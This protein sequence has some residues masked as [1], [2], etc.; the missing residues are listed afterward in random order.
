MSDPRD[1]ILRPVVSE[2]SLALV[3]AHPDHRAYTFVVAPGSN[4][5]EIRHAVEAIFGVEVI[6]ITTLNRQGKRKRNRGRAT[7]TRRPT[8]KRAVVTLAAGQEIEL[9]SES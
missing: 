2:K 5:A 7:F 9:L 6:K 8:T 3:D 4:K 1:V